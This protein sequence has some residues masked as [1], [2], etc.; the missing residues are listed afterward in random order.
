MPGP[1]LPRPSSFLLAVVE[2]GMGLAVAPLTGTLGSPLLPLEQ[3][4]EGRPRGSCCWDPGDESPTQR[5]S[6]C[7]GASEFGGC[8]SLFF[9]FFSAIAGSLKSAGL[10]EPVTDPRA[11]A[12]LVPCGSP[13]PLR[14]GPDDGNM[15]SRAAGEG[16]PGTTIRDYASS[17]GPSSLLYL[18]LVCY[19]CKSYSM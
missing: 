13:R 17:P 8:F 10:T 7:R 15:G 16:V 6:W 5:C 9:Q 19:R 11:P 12:G 4:A 3:E 2:T 18:C 1:Q 14:P